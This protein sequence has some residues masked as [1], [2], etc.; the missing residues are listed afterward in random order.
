MV[1]TRSGYDL[2]R[3]STP[4]AGVLTSAWAAPKPRL[5]D[6]PEPMQPGLNA[7]LTVRAVQSP[8]IPE[9][10]VEWVNFVDHLAVTPRQALAGDR[11]PAAVGAGSSSL[12]NWQD[13]GSGQQA[14]DPGN[15]RMARQPTQKSAAQKNGGGAAN[16]GSPGHIFWV[17]PAFKVDY[18]GHFTPL[19]PKEKF[20]EW[21]ESA[22]D[23]L[24]FGTTA[25]EA[26]TLEY[27]SS[28]G[29]CGYGSSFAGYTKCLGSM[30]LDA[31]D[32]SFLGDFVFTVWWHQD[33]RYFRLGEGSFGRRA[34]YAMSRVF[35]TYNDSGKNVFYSSA[36]AGTGIAAVLSNLYYPQT[37]R[38][39]GHTITRATI[40]L[41]DT[42]IYNASA[43]FWPEIHRWVRR[44]F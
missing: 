42:A 26:G 17:V 38:T 1:R 2:L 33:P 28:D 4:R 15:G 44:R 3:D 10:P 39:V 9:P 7:D 18:A 37:D 19:T 20:K 43:E 30:E 16:S 36:L 31:N 8:A 6:A 27:S 32:S 41:G 5:P 22:Y 34:L 12:L 11:W 29:F 14:G 23:P 21:A 24:G 35:V 25:F 40:D 13:E